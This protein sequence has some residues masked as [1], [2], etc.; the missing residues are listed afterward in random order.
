MVVQDVDDAVQ[1]TD[2][3]VAVDRMD[4][5]SKHFGGEWDRLNVIATTI[6]SLESAVEG[7]SN[8]DTFLA[9]V[10]SETPDLVEL[11]VC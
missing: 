5:D 6:K 1:A 7:I 4:G 11:S 8:D 2:V 9:F 10:V 3:H